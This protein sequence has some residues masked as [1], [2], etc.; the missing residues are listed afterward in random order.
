MGKRWTEEEVAYLRGNKDVMLINALAERLNR[1][2]VSVYCKIYELRGKN[3][4]NDGKPW[5]YAE[6]RFLADNLNVMNSKMCQKLQRG[7]KDVDMM[8]YRI[9]HGLEDLFVSA[10]TPTKKKAAKTPGRVC[11]GTVDI[12]KLEKYFRE[13]RSE[14][15]KSL[16]QN[17]VNSYMLETS[18]TRQDELLRGLCIIV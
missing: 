15:M 11:K 4:K 14:Q 17:A 2:V 1:S 8:R 7:P 10:G 16:V 9:R 5:T 13:E 18:T 6:K 12:A 3:Y